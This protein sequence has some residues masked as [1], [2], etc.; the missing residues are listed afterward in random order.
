MPDVF[1]AFDEAHSLLSTH[2]SSWLSDYSELREALTV[3]SRAPLFTFF[4]STS[5]IISQV[6]L[7]ISSQAPRPFIDLG[8]DHLMWNRK[9]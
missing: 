6:P 5:A 1:V 7:P 3:F 4:V 2:S 8:F 9:V